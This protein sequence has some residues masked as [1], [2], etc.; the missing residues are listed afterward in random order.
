[1]K[2]FLRFNSTIVFSSR[3]RE[4]GLRFIDAVKETQSELVVRRDKP[5]NLSPPLLKSKESHFSYAG[6]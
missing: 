6:N 1:M 2:I 3:F 4:N 5:K